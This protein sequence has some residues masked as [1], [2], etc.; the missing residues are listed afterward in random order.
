MNNTPSAQN[1]LHKLSAAALRPALYAYYPCFITRRALLSSPRA[2]KSNALPCRFGRTS[3]AR[4]EVPGLQLRGQ[5]DGAANAPRRINETDKAIVMVNKYPPLRAFAWWFALC[6]RNG[7]I[8]G[9]FYDGTF[10]LLND[11][12]RGM[13]INFLTYLKS[14]LPLMTMSLRIILYL[15]CQCAPYRGPIKFY[16]SILNQPITIITGDNL[17]SISFFYR[18]RTWK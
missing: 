15:K 5:I 6:T 7:Y 11:N 9:I 14:Y 1:R 8:H 3:T 16:M 10:M 12:G 13:R 4:R 17:K 2:A 18:K